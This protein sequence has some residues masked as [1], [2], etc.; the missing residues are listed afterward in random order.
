MALALFRALLFSVATPTS[1]DRI[2]AA[3]TWTD[4]RIKIDYLIMT[5]YHIDHV[6]GA[7]ALLAKLPVETFIDHG[8]NREEI[9]ADAS[10]PL[11]K[12][13]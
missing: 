5:H 12:W 11:T 3:A 4:S 6:G 10:L 13:L 1:A 8:P 9:P 2:A 7:E